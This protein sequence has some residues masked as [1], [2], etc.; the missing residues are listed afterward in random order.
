MGNIQKSYD[1][2]IRTC[3][4]P[5]V[6]YSQ[7][8]RTGQ[9]INGVTYYDCSSFI[10]R[11]LTVGG[12]FKKN[13][14]FTTR[15]MKSYL[16][17]AG[18][19]KVSLLG[20]WKPG[21]IIWRYGHTEMVYKAG[22]DAGS[23]YTMG[24]HSGRY[25]LKDQVS[26]NTYVSY[27][28]SWVELWRYKG[29]ADPNHEYK[30]IKGNRYLNNEEMQNNAYL[31]YSVMYGYG[32]DFKSI[33]AMLG[34]I[35]RESGINP[36]LWQSLK[37]NPKMGYGLVQWT[38]STNYTDWAK[39]HGYSIDDGNYQCKWIAELSDSKQW[40]KTQAYPLT[41]KEFANNTKKKS[42]DYLTMAFLKNFERAGVEKADERKKYA[43]QWYDYLRNM[44]VSVPPD[45][46]NEKSPFKWWIYQPLL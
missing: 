20:A 14:W 1:W 32:F 43:K 4:N 19:E 30:W 24:A 37:V 27:A 28:K 7:S 17:K 22:K 44:D 45:S 11:A 34:N 38:P 46:V 26:I 10:S 18:F 16:K 31:F 39:S 36:G 41:W 21:D 15:S 8:H 42:L 6:G 3:N 29:G 35:Q 23:G 13:P 25:P 12:F 9:K 40:I 5:K 33:C 2:G